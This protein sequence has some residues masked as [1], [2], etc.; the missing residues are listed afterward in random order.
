MKKHLLLLALLLAPGPA[1][2]QCNGVFPSNTV[3]GNVAVTSKPPTIIPFASIP[4][5]LVIGSTVITPSN[6]TVL[7]NNSGILGGNAGLTYVPGGPLTISPTASS[8]TKGFVVSET[9]PNSGTTVGPF[10][11]NSITTTDGNY[12]VPLVG[13]DG[14]GLGDWLASA[15]RVNYTMSYDST[16]PRVAGTFAINFTGTSA[17]AQPIAVLASIYTNNRAQSMWGVIGNT[18]VG[19]AGRSD[20]V[21]P[22][23]AETSSYAGALIQYR[24][25][26]T[27]YSEGPVQ[28]SV[29]DSA[30]TVAAQDVGTGT[31]AGWQNVIAL[32]ASLGGSQALATTGNFFSSQNAQTIG[33]FANLPNITVTNSIFNFPNFI[34][35]GGGGAIMGEGATAP[36]PSGL[37]IKSGLAQA[38]VVSANTGFTIGA[39]TVDTSNG[40]GNGV[41]V[42][43]TAAG[44]GANITTVSS[45]TNEL[46][47]LNA[48]GNQPV[49]I[50]NVSTGG[51]VLSGAVVGGTTMTVGGGS[52]GSDT[53]EVTGSTTHNGAVSIVGAALS[54]SGNQSLAAW[55]T[56]GVKLKGVASTLTD[57]TSS[58]TVA[59]AYTNVLGGNTIAASSAATFTNYFGLYLNDP[60]QGTNVTLT[61]KWALGADSAKF[62]TSNQVTI[63]NAGVLSAP[64]GITATVTG[65]ASLDLALTG[66]TMSGAIAMGGNNITGGGNAAFTTFNGNTF[67]TGTGTLTIAAAKTLTVSNS[68]TFAGTDS[69]TMTFPGTSA[70]IARTD[71][72]QTFTGVNTFSSTISGSINGNAAT[73]TTNA[74]LTGAVTS[75]GNA[76]SLGSFTSA[77]LSGALT[78][79]TGSG[80][81]VFG[82]SPILTTVDA[83]G[84]WTAG[85]TW[86]LPAHT[87]GGTV[88]GGGNNINNVN[89]GVSTPGTGAFTTIT[90]TSSVF[91]GL[92]NIATTSAVCFNT[93]TGLLSYDGTLGTCTVSDE[94]LKNMGEHIP[95]ALNRLLQINGVYYTW[96]DPKRMGKGRQIGVGAQTVEKVFPELVQADSSG[97]KSADYQRL[98]A[99]IIE[100]IRELKHNNDNLETRMIRL[101]NRK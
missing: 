81:A 91:F 23:V 51:V 25:G 27:A 4:S 85:A 71:A 75:V 59:S 97:Y 68:I 88:S 92:A 31:P 3:C 42:Y 60:V 47:A 101:E 30:M 61:N 77:N 12:S 78:D 32:S 76:A 41:T 62:G 94:R 34:V 18:S 96:K 24:S 9:G 65:H 56:S 53:L 22:I 73:V 64:G 29:L 8:F 82:T 80:S 49:Y 50:A 44:S 17:I 13:P 86:T 57:T 14:F 93:G 55:T 48:K 83:R 70:T 36:G 40:S 90:S 7:F 54:L 39:F 87:L 16:S 45:N 84:V 1:F 63:T 74:N 43:S 5:T 89:I 6:T 33:S 99:P 58:G 28:G 79:E 100:A 2:A 52:I 37:K 26:F 98:V 95:N 72:A 35:N 11:Y 10:N 15:F 67:T 38:L 19:A 69:T 20:F 21:F 66:G 46:I